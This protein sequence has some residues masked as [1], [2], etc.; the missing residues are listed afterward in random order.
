[1]IDVADD[2]FALFGPLP[3]TLLKATCP[4]CGATRFL[5][6]VSNVHPDDGE[7]TAADA[8]ARGRWHPANRCVHGVGPPAAGVSVLAEALR[9][10][11]PEAYPNDAAK[12]VRAVRGEAEG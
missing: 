11:K 10:R 12:T 9:R 3:A 8:F 2:P 5:F 7:L 6:I 4:D 1:V